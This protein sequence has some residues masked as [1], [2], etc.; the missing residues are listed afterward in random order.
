[1]VKRATHVLNL[2]FE[3]I[4]ST[5]QQRWDV[6]R[7]GGLC[8]NVGIRALLLLLHALIKHAQ[9]K[10]K[11]FDPSNAKP[12]EIVE[13]ALAIAKPVLEFLKNVTDVDFLER[14]SGKYGSG[15]P[16]EYFYELCS[17][18]WQQDNTFS[19]EGLE[20]YITAKDSTRIKEAEA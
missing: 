12:E 10:R 2:F 20:Q 16:V 19:P 3:E 8:V 4:R 18:L 7:Q 9:S 11:N 15:G 13:Q 1:T 6:G 14:F 5:N 17:L